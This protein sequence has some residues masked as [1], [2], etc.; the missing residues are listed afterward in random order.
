[1]WKFNAVLNSY[2]RMSAEWHIVNWYPIINQLTYIIIT[3]YYI[4]KYYTKIRSINA[5]FNPKN[6]LNW[7][8][9]VRDQ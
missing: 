6:L 7:N 3:L 9:I 4:T 1:M 8:I 2:N 5:V